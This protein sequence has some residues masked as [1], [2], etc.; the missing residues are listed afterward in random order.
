MIKEKKPILRDGS[1]AAFAIFESVVDLAFIT[2]FRDKL[3][4]A[5]GDITFINNFDKEL[6]QLLGA[7]DF[8][9]LSRQTQVNFIK[10]FL[11]K[12][13]HNF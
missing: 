2:T 3:H 10:A 6:G 11:V 5:S 9:R 8:N 13:M 1:I 7:D 4:P 12:F